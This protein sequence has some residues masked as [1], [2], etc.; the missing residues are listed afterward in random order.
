M[1][2]LKRPL[3]NELLTGAHKNRGRIGAC[4]TIIIKNSDPIIAVSLY[5]DHKCMIYM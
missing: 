2:P 3:Q 4:G 5:K 1:T